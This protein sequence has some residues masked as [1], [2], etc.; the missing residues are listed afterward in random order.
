M[1][2]RLRL[3]RFAAFLLAAACLSPG[4]SRAGDG[5]PSSVQ[6]SYDV[7]FNGL[8]VGT[9]DFQSSQEGQSYRLASN[10]KLS[11]LLGALRWT[12]TTHS[13]GKLAG[14]T[15]KPQAFGFDY[16]AQSKSGSTQ[17]AFTDDTVTQVLHSPPPKIKEGI[18]PVE[19][20]HLKGVLDPLTAVMALSR[21]GS[22]ANP[23][24][25]RIPVY[26]GYQR[27]D[28]VLTPKGQTA[29]DD[30]Q[31]PGHT[32]T[33]FVCR[34]RYVP[35]AGHKADENT[36]YMA[37]NNDIE[38]ILRAVP[39]SNI[40]IPQQVT[41]PTIAGAATLVARRVQVAINGRQQLAL[42]ND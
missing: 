27:F 16:K 42:V 23:C 32:T 17:M 30:P 7:N 25:K 29:I 22:T 18:V 14:D 12:G 11:L 3:P 41:I 2:L 31:A 39:A 33:G 6:A 1:L 24:S 37:H 28:L 13:S 36:K 34:V 8:N 4:E 38:I 9:Y 19:A 26:D 10:A 35:I 21:G 40:F 15:A 20:Q 5:W